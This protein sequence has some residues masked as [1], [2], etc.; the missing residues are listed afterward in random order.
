[1]LLNLLFPLPA[2]VVGIL[3]MR[4]AGVPTTAWGQNLAA[5]VIGILLYF[6]LARPRVS[7]QGETGLLIA[8]VLA[9]G[10]LAATWLDPGLQ[11]VH[12]WLMLGPVR[13]HAGALVLPLVLAALAGLE[14][15]GRRGASTLLA[16]ATALVLALQP[17][18]AQATAFVAGAVVL[19]LPRSPAEGR[20]WIRLLP[21]VVLAGLSWLRKDPLAPVPH[22]EG[23]VGLAAEQ[24]HVWGIAAVASLLLLPV[25]FFVARGRGDGRVGLALGA[26]IIVTILATAVAHFPVPVLG[27]GA[28]PILGYFVA[29]GLL[30]R[31]QGSVPRGGTESPAT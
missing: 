17:D 23:I 10:V 20:G 7:R 6:V 26:Y 8:G 25:P 30:K 29:I 19:L 2:L 24:G 16:I 5:C 11:G 27:Q 28:S 14:R 31:F 4:A 15:A 13:V 18:A 9:L 21:L 12:R 1:M 3:I 22:V